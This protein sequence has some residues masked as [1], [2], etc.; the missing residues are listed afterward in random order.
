M[1]KVE[2]AQDGVVIQGVTAD[3]RE[4]SRNV[5]RTCRHYGI[6]RQAY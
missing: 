3:V 5:A 6:F 2:L 1:T 4:R